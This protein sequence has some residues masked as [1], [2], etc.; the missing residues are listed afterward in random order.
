MAKAES[1]GSDHITG[2]YINAA[3]MSELRNDQ[4]SSTASA[5]ESGH[6]E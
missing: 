5:C 1:R 3:S 6:E 4:L 2:L